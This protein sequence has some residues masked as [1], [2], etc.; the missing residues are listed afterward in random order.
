GGAAGRRGRGD[1]ACRVPRAG[2]RRPRRPGRCAAVAVMTAARQRPV[3]RALS[4]LVFA[5]PV[6]FVLLIPH[7]L[8]QPFGVDFTLYRDVTIRWLGGG[9]YLE[10]YHLAGP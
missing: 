8:E 4:A 7:P 1:R 5:T 6:L 9:P 10:P 2:A 3:A